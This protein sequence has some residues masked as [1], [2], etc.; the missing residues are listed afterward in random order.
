MPRFTTAARRPVEDP[1]DSLTKEELHAID[2][3]V[4]A[5]VRARRIYLG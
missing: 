4:G 2:V 5:N 3:R 1:T